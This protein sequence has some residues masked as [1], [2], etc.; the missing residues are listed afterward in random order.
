MQGS[1]FDENGNF[2]NWW[3]FETKKKY[4]EKIECFVDQYENIPIEEIDERVNTI[5]FFQGHRSV[6]NLKIRDS[7]R[8]GSEAQLASDL[9]ADLPPR[10]HNCNYISFAG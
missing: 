5:N 10:D 8:N 9:V 7:K 4:A 6:N 3:Q 1:N 2:K